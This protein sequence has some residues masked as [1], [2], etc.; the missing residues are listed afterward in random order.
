MLY[1][2]E[3]LTLMTADDDDEDDDDDMDEEKEEEEEGMEGGPEIGTGTD[4]GE[5]PEF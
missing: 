1:E 5:E 4:E 3:L 2:F